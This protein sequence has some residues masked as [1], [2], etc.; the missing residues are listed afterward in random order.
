MRYNQVIGS[1]LESTLQLRCL[2]EQMENS[3]LEV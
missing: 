1:Y 2:G 3:S